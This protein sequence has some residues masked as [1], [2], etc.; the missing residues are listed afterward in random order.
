MRQNYSFGM[1]QMT[2]IFHKLLNQFILTI[3]ILTNYRL[4]VFYTVSIT[5]L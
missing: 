1:H 2:I 3:D 4:N 5:I